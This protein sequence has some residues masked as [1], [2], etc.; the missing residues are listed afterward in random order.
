MQELIEEGEYFSEEAIKIRDPL[1]YHMY[2][3]R[4]ERNG[5]IKG[6]ALG[7]SAFIFQRIDE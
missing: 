1:M 5:D 3:G 4:F 2:V 7:M 6:D